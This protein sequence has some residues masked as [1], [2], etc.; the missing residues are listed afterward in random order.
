MISLI[1]WSIQRLKVRAELNHW[2]RFHWRGSVFWKNPTLFPADRL[3]AFNKHDH[4]PR[5][6][7]DR[8]WWGRIQSFRLFAS[9]EPA[10]LWSSLCG[11]HFDAAIGMAMAFLKTTRRFAGMRDTGNTTGTIRTMEPTNAGADRIISRIRRH[12]TG[13]CQR[14]EATMINC[15]HVAASWKSLMHFIPSQIPFTV[16]IG[17]ALKFHFSN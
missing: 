17:D 6:D 2:R 16:Q 1:A 3:T 13:D 14:H 4:R 9:A 11:W 7:H 12:K 15:F 8:H 5:P 10:K